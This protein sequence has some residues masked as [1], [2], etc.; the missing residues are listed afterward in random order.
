MSYGEVGT[1]SSVRRIGRGAKRRTR[2]LE[3]NRRD[4]VMD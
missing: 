2:E 3:E 4:E 1:R